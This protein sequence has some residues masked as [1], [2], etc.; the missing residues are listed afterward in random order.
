MELY[1]V[2]LRDF[3]IKA[4]R[5]WET[6]VLSINSNLLFK[7]TNFVRNLGLIF[8]Y[9]LNHLKQRPSGFFLLQDAQASGCSQ[10][11]CCTVLQTFLQLLFSCTLCLGQCP[12]LVFSAVIVSFEFFVERKQIEGSKSE[13]E[14]GMKNLRF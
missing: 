7:K 14:F 11:T 1:L 6:L 10:N 13:I 9:N 8:Q 2:K 12:K 4:L 3:M 5:L